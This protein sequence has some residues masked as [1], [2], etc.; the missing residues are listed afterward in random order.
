MIATLLRCCNRRLKL[1]RNQ[2]KMPAFFLLSTV[3]GSLSYGAIDSVYFQ[4]GPDQG[5]DAHLNSRSPDTGNSETDRFEA[6]VWTHDHVPYTT[7]SCIDFDITS[8]LG[9]RFPLQATLHLFV[10]PGGNNGHAVLDQNS[11]SVSFARIVSPWQENTVTWAQMTDTMISP[12]NMTYLPNTTDSFLSAA[13]DVTAHIWDYMEDNL[14]HGFLMSILTT[15]E[16][17]RRHYASSNYATD[18]TRPA[19]ELLLTDEPDRYITRL[20]T[21]S[22]EVWDAMLSTTSPDNNYGER[23]NLVANY[24]TSSGSPIYTY[25]LINFNLQRTAH[26][27]LRKAWLKLR[28]PRTGNGHFVAEGYMVDTRFSIQKI[29]SAWDENSVTYSS[30]PS[31]EPISSFAT[32][33]ASKDKYQDYTFDVTDVIEQAFEQPDNF[34]GFYFAVK[35][36]YSAIEFASSEHD[37]VALRPQLMLLY[38]DSLET[39]GM[40]RQNNPRVRHTASLRIGAPGIFYDLRGRAIRKI[41]QS[42]SPGIILSAKCDKRFQPVFL[43][44]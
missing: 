32:V 41:D 33:P 11:N 8:L 38:E 4:P 9:G 43:D 25:I 35:Y 40:R 6:A 26:A 30:A 18:S 16:W 13:V 29:T 39:T 24:W 36:R 22:A 27:P 21:D 17:A 5:I 42:I 15:R 7:Q 20:G 12:H 14:F 31:I 2:S 34:H 44:K 1:I 37:S 10:P 23:S 28:S 19:L 3:G